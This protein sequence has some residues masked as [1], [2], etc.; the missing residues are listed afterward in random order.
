MRN[1]RIELLAPAGDRDCFL[2]ALNAGADAVYL[3]LKRFG[4][5]ANAGN[6]TREELLQSLDT[7]HMHGMKIY[8]TVNTLFKDREMDELYDLLYD[9]YINGLDGVI[10]QDIG[11]MSYICD[12]FPKLPIHVSTQAGITAS[13]GARFLLPLQVKRIVPARELSLKEIRKLYEDT[14]L[15]IECFIHGSMCYSYSGKCLLS[16]FIGGRSG[17]RGRCAQPCRL[18]YDGGYPLSLKD[19]CTIDMID[20][21]AHSGVSSFKIEGRMKS[22]AYV[23]GVTSL[24]RKY[25]DI[26]ET[27]GKCDVSSRDRSRLI[28]IYTRSGNCSG[29][30]KCHNDSSMIT[31]GSPSYES[32]TEPCPSEAVI[33]PD[34]PVNISCSIHTGEK[35]VICIYNDDHSIGQ[36]V[37]IIAQKACNHS[38]TVETVENQLKRCGGSGFRAENVE[39]SVDEGLFLTKGQLNEIRRAGLEA[40]SDE[41]LRKYRRKHDHL[42]EKSREVC[43]DH[44]ELSHDSK[45]ETRISV[46]DKKQLEVSVSSDADTLIIPMSLADEDV[47]DI[48]RHTGKKIC[49]SLPVIVRDEDRANSSHNIRSFIESITKEPDINGF[50]VSNLESLQILKDLGYKGEITADYMFYAYNSRACGYLRKNG[51]ANTVVPVELNM[52]ELSDRAIT[53]EELMIYGRIPVMI[54]ANCIQKTEKT[55]RRDR[56]GNRLYITDRKGEKLFVYCNC[57]ECVNTIYNSVVLSIADENAL[58][59]RIRPSVVRLSFTDESGEET[60]RIIDRYF[61]GRNKNGSC[62]INPVEDKYTRGHLKRGVE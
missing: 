9:P 54:S 22:S 56:Y 12:T 29:Y 49:I 38:L 21:L 28:S 46:L 33:S 26:F 50:Y 61:A 7:A 37:D 25:L 51:I 48:L 6:F 1:N 5:R 19:M 55:C 16:S 53:G 45:V 32:S 47:L 52:H 58:F 18:M 27:T 44:D 39:V 40:F 34:I 59:E 8:L 14:N 15:E 20:E 10:V 36:E 2:A 42:P 11:V 30:Y 4:A 3:G 57:N 31:Q 35:A 60:K 62:K 23:Y 24:Y 43:D 13:A 17:N 41:I